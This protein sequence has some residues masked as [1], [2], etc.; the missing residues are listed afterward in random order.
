MSFLSFKSMLLF[1]LLS[2]III[3]NGLGEISSTSIEGMVKD[4]YGNPISDAQVQLTPGNILE[5]TDFEGRFILKELSANTYSLKIMHISYHQQYINNISI[6]LN[7]NFNLG[8]IILTGKIFSLQSTVVTA[9]RSQKEILSISNSINIVDEIEINNR[10]AKTSAEALR[11]ESG[12][13]IQKTNH[14]GGSAIIRGLS[15]NQILLMVDGIRLNNSTYRLGNH[16]YLTTVDNNMIEQIEVVR[17]PTSLQYGSDALGGTINMVTQTPEFSSDKMKFHYKLMS[18]YATADNEKLSRAQFSLHK[19]K[20]AFTAGFSYKDFG[21]MRRGGNSHFPE[22]ENSTNGLKQSPSGFTAYDFDSKL[23]YA[24]TNS[25]LLI[26]NYQMNRQNNVPRYDKY[27]SNNYYK[28]IYDPQKRDLFYIKYQ[29]QLNKKYLSS[30]DLSLVYHR[31]Q[32]GRV[33][34]K[35][36]TSS[37]EKNLDDVHTT[38]IILQFNTFLHKQILTYGVDIY[39]DKVLSSK[40]MTSTETGILQKQSNGR[41]PDNAH[42]NSIGV[43]LQD[44]CQASDNILLSGGIRYNRYLSDF[45]FP[46]SPLDELNLIK[47]SVDFKA[48]T[49][50]L[51]LNYKI[52]Q[53]LSFNTNIAHAFRAPNLSDMA[54]LDESKGDVYEIPNFDLKPE[55]LVNYEMGIKAGFNRFSSNFTVYHSTISSLI[56]SASVS[57]NNSDSIEIDGANYKLKSKQ[58]IGEAYIQGCELFFNYILNQRFTLISNFS[59]TFGQNTTYHEPV[60]G[61]PPAFGLV[62][63]K[64]DYNKYN[65]YFYSRFATKQDRLSADDLDDNRIPNSGTPAWFTINL[66]MKFPVNDKVT[67]RFSIE[68]ILDYNYREHGSGINGPGRN[69]VL[70]LVIKQ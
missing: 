23:V 26:F 6:Q 32:E 49:G 42:Y 30:I 63:I 44:E 38:G 59:Y 58:N 52:S 39:N 5:F 48:L 21:D 25:Q 37:L 61:I 69:F 68:N 66:R 22:L 56:A 17:G 24:L 70:G 20:A 33:K 64:Y 10:N 41:Y 14:G 47:T 15:S 7:E 43:F 12:V 11:E 36:E 50:S 18:R 65:F 3:S 57:L 51:G 53:H 9:T 28:W 29:N 4:I 31:Q 62:G 55:K 35:K 2:T 40:H 8:E 16:Q 67:L 46:S 27:E 13:F 54:K 19:R 34:Q 45:T 1:L 60:G